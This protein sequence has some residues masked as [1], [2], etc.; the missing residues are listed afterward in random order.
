MGYQVGNQCFLDKK[1]A[2]N[3]YFSLVVPIVGADGKIHKPEY[4]VN[5]WKMNGEVLEAHLPE[6]DPEQNLKDGLQLGWLIFGILA[7]VW[8]ITVIRRLLR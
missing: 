2:E 1:Q 4:L 3:Y 7:L 5:Q 8:G 6:C